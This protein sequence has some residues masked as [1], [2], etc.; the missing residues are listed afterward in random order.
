MVPTII[1][2]VDGKLEVVL[3]VRYPEI[4]TIEDI[5]KKFNL[6]MEQNNI[7][8]FELIGENLKQANYIDR[9]S[10]L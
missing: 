10:N 2:I 9:N 7:N 4:L 1:N 8:K 3:S 5:I 6:Y